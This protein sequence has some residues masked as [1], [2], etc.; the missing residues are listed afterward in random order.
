M[1]NFILPDDLIEKAKKDGIGQTQSISETQKKIIKILLKDRGVSTDKFIESL[2]ICLSNLWLNSARGFYEAVL[3]LEDILNAGRIDEI[4]KL[5]G[6]SEKKKIKQFQQEVTRLQKKFPDVD[7]GVIKR[8]A[9][10]NPNDTDAHLD[11]YVKTLKSLT[12]QFPDEKISLL[13]H[14]AK[15]NPNDPEAAVLE[16]QK[17]TK[18]L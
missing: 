16:H 18:R 14:F 3:Y 5:V 11:K 8:Y 10:N 9:N 7:I 4:T 6:E 15:S 12:K 13:K 17:T 1:L 2:E